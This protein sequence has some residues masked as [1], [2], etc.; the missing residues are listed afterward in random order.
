MTRNRILPIL[1]LAGT[2]LAALLAAGTPLNPSRTS[3]PSNPSDP[4]TPRGQ[5]VGLDLND[6]LDKVDAKVG[7]FQEARNW[8]GSVTS[9]ITKMN[10]HWT[11]ESVTVVTK[12]VTVADGRRSEEILKA[13]ETKDGKTQDITKEF[14]E[15][16]R[17][18]H[19]KYRRQR[20]PDKPRPAGTAPR[21]RGLG[22]SIEEYTPFSEA[23]RKLFDFRL[24]ENASLDGRPAL[25]LD[26]T[27]K[28]KSDKNWEGRIY[29]EPGT[30]DPLLAE[31]RPSETPRFVKELEAR[32]ALE[33][34]G[35][36][37]LMLK[38]TWIKVNAGF[39]FFKRVR[40]V[41][42]DLYSDIEILRP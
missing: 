26:V 27:A 23:R 36:T 9:T 3:G 16:D 40:Q 42:E 8:R 31:A 41:V 38:S 24:D 2:C 21:R 11:P 15:T 18:E 25:A 29:F 33:V 37:T 7:G 35:G 17:K 32:I 20:P 39:L 13:L 4:S 22:A 30:L 34:V 12:A 28:V 5:S 1:I 6:F 19:E 10:R 14:I